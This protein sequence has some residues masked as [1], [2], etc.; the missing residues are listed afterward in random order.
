[1]ILNSRFNFK[2]SSETGSN[3]I[4]EVEEF[5]V[6]F[7]LP[8][9]LLGVAVGI[10]A[11]YVS[12]TYK[13]LPMLKLDVEAK[14]QEVEVLQAKVNQ[15]TA[16]EQNK[17]LVVADLVKMSWALEERDKVPELTRQIRLMSDDSRVV[18]KS[19]DYANANKDQL[20]SVPVDSGSSSALTPDPELYREEKVNVDIE[21]KGFTSVIDFLRTAENSIRLFK[22][23]SIKISTFNQ[24]N[25]ADVVMASPYLNP[26]FSTYSQ[27]AAPIDLTDPAYRSFMERLDTFKNYAREIDAALPKI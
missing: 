1:M 25:K 20:V 8:I 13:K 22:V 10:F 5:V 18:F 21:V 23:E 3:I 26:A 15:L 12:P 7:I 14:T 6:N 9:I 27:S 11:L 19:L 16:L 17:D 2:T 24:V 4:T